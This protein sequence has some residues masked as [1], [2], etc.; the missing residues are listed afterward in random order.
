MRSA[1]FMRHVTDAGNQVNVY[2]A[3]EIRQADIRR[4]VDRLV[5]KQAGQRFEFLKK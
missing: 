1:R 3:Q 2:F 5:N 4:S